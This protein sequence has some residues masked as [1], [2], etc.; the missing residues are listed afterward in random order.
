MITQ[1]VL[2]FASIFTFFFLLSSC[3]KDK[4]VIVESSCPEEVAYSIQVKQII[5]ETCAYADCHDG[6]SNAPGDFTSYSRMESFLTENKFVRRT[7]DLRDM[8][9]SNSSGPKSL[10]QEQLDM[11]ICWIEGDYKD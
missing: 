2:Q 3:T 7:I 10:T 5:D 1:K 6:G 8:P 4:I 11:L 9:P